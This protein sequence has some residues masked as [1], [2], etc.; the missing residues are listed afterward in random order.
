MKR[1]ILEFINLLIIFRQMF[2]LPANLPE[3]P[4]L[5]NP[6]LADRLRPSIVMAH[7]QARMNFPTGSLARFPERLQS[8]SFTIRR[9]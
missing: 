7:P 9:H 8:T 2:A 1:S 4:F 6:H 5:R 3:P